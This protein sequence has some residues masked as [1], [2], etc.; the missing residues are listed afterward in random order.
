MQHIVIVGN[1]GAARECYWIFQEMLQADS[2]LSEH[3]MFKG[4]LAWKNYPDNLKDLTCHSLGEA[5]SYIL[6]P[7]DRIVIG[8]GHPYLR[9]EV[10]N[11]FKSKNA[12]F[13]TLCHPLAD[14]NPTAK[15]G[16]ANIFQRGSSVFCDAIL[17]DANYLNGT[18]NLSHDASVGSF[19]FLGPLTLLLGNCTVGNKNS[20]AARCTILPG[21]KIGNNNIIAPNSVVYKGCGSNARMVGNPAL[22]IASYMPEATLPCRNM[23]P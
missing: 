4:F 23:Q 9:E 14:I 17:G 5:T 19:N 16:E 21:A 10:F 2:T 13:F 1:A 18:V 12:L 22:K 20:I 8:I 11:Y 6:S 15:I 3:Y 7:D